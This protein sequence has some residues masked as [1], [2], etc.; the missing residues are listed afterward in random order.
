MP[1]TKSLES[2]QS[3]S[4]SCFFFDGLNHS[5]HLYGVIWENI[6]ICSLKAN[7]H[8]S[9]FVGMP[10]MAERNELSFREFC[11][12]GDWLSTPGPGDSDDFQHQK[13]SVMQ[14]PHEV[15][16]ILVDLSRM[17]RYEWRLCTFPGKKITC[18]FWSLQEVSLKERNAKRVE[19]LTTEAEKNVSFWG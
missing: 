1:N 4:L 17:F 14:W 18:C 6:Q 10:W 19:Q 15:W 5:L 11:T 7:L 2:N 9:Q 3:I 13:L 16:Y 12:K 8:M